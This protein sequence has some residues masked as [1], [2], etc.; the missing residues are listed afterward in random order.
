MKEL[1]KLLLALAAIRAHPRPD[2]KGFETVQRVADGFWL[3]K[4]LVYM[5]EQVESPAFRPSAHLDPFVEQFAPQSVTLAKVEKG[6]VE[7]Q[8]AVRI[9]R[10]PSVVSEVNCLTQSHTKSEAALGRP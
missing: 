6:S 5:P 10:F 4:G 7:K 3:K 8:Q 9:L 1:K 2:E